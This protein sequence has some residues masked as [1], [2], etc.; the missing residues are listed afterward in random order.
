MLKKNKPTTKQTNK[1]QQQEKTQTTQHLLSTF[2]QF[3]T[4]ENA[5]CSHMISILG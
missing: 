3:Y 4:F 2:K 5:C 1:R